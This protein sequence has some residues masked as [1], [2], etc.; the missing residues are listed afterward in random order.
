MTASQAQA[1]SPAQETGPR[2][3]ERLLAKRVITEAQLR[4][5]LQIQ[6]QSARPLGRV[7]VELGVLDEDRLTAVLGEHLDVPVVNLGRQEVDA[8]AARLVP[9]EFARR[10]VVLPISRENGDL[11]VAMADPANLHLIND[12]RLITGL[13]IVP[14][15]AG[16]SDILA[17]LSRIHSMGPRIH[18]AARS[19]EESRPRLANG[20][21]TIFELSN[22]TASSPAIDIVNMMITQGL[23]D[24]ASDIHIEPQKE[25]L[26]IRFR[27][28]GV[29]QD[30][31]HLPIA[32]GAALS[33][34]IKIMADMN[35]V[36]RRRAQDGQISLNVDGRELDIRV[37]TI[38]T[39]WGEKL[40]MRLLDRGRSLI[41]L[42]QLG[43]SRS[44]YERFQTML[45]SPYG[46]IIVS[47]PTGSGKTTTLYASIHQLDQ[48]VRNIMTIE[49][50][51]EYTFDNINQSQINKLADIS[52]ANGLRA[53]LRQ[54]PDIILVGEI[55]DRETA[56]IAVQSALTGHLVLSSLH[57]TD[58]VGALL[59]FIDMGIE[60]FLIASSVIAI[61]AQRLVRKV[62]DGCKT[63]HA[64]TVEE[65]EFAASLG[66]PVPAQ[67]FHGV[68]C[69]RCNHTGYYD[70]LGVFEVLT[71]SDELKRLVITKASHREIMA[72]AVAGGVVPL[73]I[74]A[75]EKASAGVTTV[76]EVLRSVYII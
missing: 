1:F 38:E 52:F 59:R 24:R 12:L 50:P 8:E 16:R 26:R 56:E 15:I 42:E 43:F 9:E 58:A 36:E 22:I 28:D 2:L 65:V 72:A 55:R 41:T 62:C 74:D 44:A 10:H 71:M 57:A 31:A 45:H 7:L 34:R 54:D 21:P 11:G 39:I 23:R 48:Q 63:P 70:R 14:H 29:L 18:E 13:G 69:G 30:V 47:G 53:I 66:R 3:G 17:N 40:V 51:V 20:R 25:Y 19:L 61:V 75:W 37:A 27:I 35:I 4:H 49:D 67:L 5:A 32:T 33:S 68:G 64:P 76:A 60:G 73:R 6:P 46:M